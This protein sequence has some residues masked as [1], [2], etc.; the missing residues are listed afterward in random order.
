[1]VGR[2]RGQR[3]RQVEK[4][5]LYL[6]H[7]LLN[8]ERYTAFTCGVTF[9][10]Q[11]A[12]LPAAVRGYPSAAVRPGRS[13]LD[14]WI[15]WRRCPGGTDLQQM[16]CQQH[17]PATDGMSAACFQEYSPLFRRGIWKEASVAAGQ[18]VPQHAAFLCVFTGIAPH[19]LAFSLPLHCL[20][21]CLH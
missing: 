9:L 4:R 13:R 10:K 6:R 3:C 14:C 17:T 20:S 19:F 21:L 5:C 18:T 7:H 1:M 2:F 15:G 8:H 12:F 16:A 11:G